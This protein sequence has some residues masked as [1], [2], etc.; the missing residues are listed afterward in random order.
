MISWVIPILS[1]NPFN[2]A[3]KYHMSQGLANPAQA[4]AAKT[5]ASADGTNFISE[6]VAKDE[7]R[8][9][10]AH[11]FRRNDCT[12]AQDVGSITDAKNG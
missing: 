5:Q 11:N 6:C 1:R 2:D 9:S 10:A 3:A 7:W 8:Q 12:V 4:H